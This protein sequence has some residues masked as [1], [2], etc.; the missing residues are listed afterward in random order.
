[1]NTN[2]S[3]SDLEETQ[4]SYK[5][6]I[7]NNQKWKDDTETLNVFH[8]EDTGVEHRPSSRETD[9]QENFGAK[10]RNPAHHSG[11]EYGNIFGPVISR[12]PDLVER[13]S[14]VMERSDFP[15]RNPL[16]GSLQRFE[17]LP[18]GDS[19]WSV[20]VLMNMNKSTVQ[21]SY[22]CQRATGKLQGYQDVSLNGQER[23]C[24]LRHQYLHKLFQEAMRNQINQSARYIG[25][26]VMT[27]Y[28]QWD[29]GTDPVHTIHCE[30]SRRPIPAYYAYR[31]SRY[32]HVCEQKQ[33]QT[34][35]ICVLKI[36]PASSQDKFN[37]IMLYRVGEPINMSTVKSDPAQHKEDPPGEDNNNSNHAVLEISLVLS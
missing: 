2:Q 5:R 9:E 33:S 16:S 22:K 23:G 6:G 4:G 10:E 19:Y 8:R 24:I 29:Q 12:Q 15:P 17:R 11:F 26:D 7:Q 18:L 28:Q 30:P 27:L 13:S 37:Q 36:L 34:G 21:P 32:R 14:Q 20:P 31:M 3:I 35:H 1:M 25:T